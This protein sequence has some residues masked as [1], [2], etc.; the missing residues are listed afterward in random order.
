MKAKDFTTVKDLIKDNL[1]EHYFCLNDM[2]P[3][4]E[5]EETILRECESAGLDIYEDKELAE[6]RGY[7]RAWEVVNP[8]KD[9]LKKVLEICRANAEYDWD[10]NMENAPEDEFK[11]IVRL[12]EEDK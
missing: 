2:I 1:P 8:Y 4:H 10:N 6:E 7:D 5:V 3:A 12:I 11:A 9:K